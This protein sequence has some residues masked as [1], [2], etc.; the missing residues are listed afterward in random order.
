MAAHSSVKKCK[1]D[2][3]FTTLR[4]CHFTFPSRFGRQNYLYFL[5]IQIYRMSIFN[6]WLI[7]GRVLLPKL[8]G[9]WKASPGICGNVLI[10]VISFCKISSSFISSSRVT[11][12]HIWKEV[13]GIHPEIANVKSCMDQVAKIHINWNAHY[14]VKR[15][16]VYHLQTNFGWNG[17]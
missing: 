1:I 10:W 15:V 14:C 5:S 7:E 6:I 3:L 12:C 4:L 17:N 16:Q 2:K 13:N 9:K 8:E 11:L